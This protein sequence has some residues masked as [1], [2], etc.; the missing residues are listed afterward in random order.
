MQLK[1]KIQNMQKYVQWTFK[2]QLQT[3]HYKFAP[4]QMYSIYFPN[5]YTKT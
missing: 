1:K 3:P 5:K 2:L 4:Y